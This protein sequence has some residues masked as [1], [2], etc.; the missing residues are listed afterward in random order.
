MLPPYPPPD[1]ETLARK[2]GKREGRGEQKEE[3]EESGGMGRR[4]S[5]T[6]CEQK[7][8]LMVNPLRVL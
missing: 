6:G 8:V 4:L 7:T 1:L 5:G 3:E 2:E